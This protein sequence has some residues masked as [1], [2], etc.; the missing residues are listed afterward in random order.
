MHEDSQRDII[1][2]PY[3]KVLIYNDFYIGSTPGA[4]PYLEAPQRRALWFLGPGKH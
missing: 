2:N 3:S 4:A 1:N